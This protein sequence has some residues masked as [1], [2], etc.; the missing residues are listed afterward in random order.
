MRLEG[1]CVIHSLLEFDSSGCVI[2]NSVVPLID[3]GTEGFKG[4]V[5]VIIPGITACFEC[6]IGLLPPAKKV[7]ICTL[8]NKPRKFDDCL[9][10]ASLVEWKDSD[11]GESVPFDPEIPERVNWAIE[12]AV[13]RAK[14]FSLPIS[15][16]ETTFRAALKTLKNIIPAIS[17]TNAIIAAMCCNEV[18]KLAG[19]IGSS[20]NNF[21]LYNGTEGVYSNSFENKRLP[22]CIV[23]SRTP[24][25][26]LE[27]VAKECSVLFSSVLEFVEKIQIKFSLKAPTI[28]NASQ[29]IY[30]T[31]VAAMVEWNEENSG[32]KIWDY[33]GPFWTCDSS[34]LQVLCLQLK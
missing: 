22:E 9:E 25:I 29:N 20:L 1:G 17:S 7:A 12:R 13:A 19:E 32:K 5:R 30:F 10:N 23:C 27:G 16:E 8:S 3:G 18:I 31:S 33:E 11:Q 24:I 15:S 14:V 34:L 21:F 28:R 2:S 4:S 6:T 26:P